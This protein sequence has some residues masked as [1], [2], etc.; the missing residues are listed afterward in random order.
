MKSLIRYPGSKWNLAQKIIDLLPEHKSYLEPYFGS[1]AV[2]FTKSPSPIETVNDL[3]DDVV[4]LFQ[5]IQSAPDVL[6]EK[7][8][9]IPYSRSIY[10]MAWKNK[11]N[12]EVD[13]AVNF[14]IRSTMSHGFR[15]FE[16]S[17]WKRD[18]SGRESAYAVQHWNRLPETVREMAVRLKGVQIENRPALQLIEEFSRPEAVIYIDPPYILSTRARKQYSHEM[19]DN[20]HIELL[21][22]LNQSKA[23]IILSGY[24]SDLYD[25]YLSNWERLEFSATAE[26]GLPRTEVL[27]M[28]FQ[29]A[30]QLDLFN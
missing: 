2:L 23:Q 28:N 25:R 15:V 7:L 17:G 1:G 9:G 21:E 20:D 30:Q 6:Q 18:V 26:R 10:E 12:N 24:T 22:L 29:P 5:V 4:N 16:K 3:N 8:W 14:I 11:P 19:T 27:W 13:K